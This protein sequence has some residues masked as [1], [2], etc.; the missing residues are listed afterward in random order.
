ML[1]KNE[2]DKPV[3]GSDPFNRRRY[4]IASEKRNLTPLLSGVRVHDDAEKR[5]NN[6]LRP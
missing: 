2:I 6:Y 4:V 3:K 5:P 1:T